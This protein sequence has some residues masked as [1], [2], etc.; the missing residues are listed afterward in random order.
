[1]QNFK[2]PSHNRSAT[3]VRPERSSVIIIIRQHEL[4]SVGCCLSPEQWLLLR[5]LVTGNSES[6][7]NGQRSRKTLSKTGQNW[8]VSGLKEAVF[9]K[10]SP[11]SANCTASN[12]P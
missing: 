11:R 2:L 6:G 4:V 10:L 5:E 9:E 1:M 7:K 12:N 8:A 3:Q